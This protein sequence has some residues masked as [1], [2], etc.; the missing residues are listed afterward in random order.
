MT[1]KLGGIAQA[2]F[3]QLL[4]RMVATEKFYGL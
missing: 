1:T 3:K 4:H 2:D